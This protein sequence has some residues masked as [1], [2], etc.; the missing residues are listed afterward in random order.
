MKT[1][2]THAAIILA[3]VPFNPNSRH[4]HWGKHFYVVVAN[5][6]ACK[7]SPVVQAVPVSSKMKRNLPV[8]VE[9]FS[10]AFS[11]RSY[12]LADQLTLLPREILEDGKLSGILCA[13]EMR[14]IQSVIKKQLA[15]D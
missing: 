8:Q 1:T 13:E 10:E 11:K 7:F 4:T 12:A 15:L 5:P 9:I 2:I 6:A 3:D 14:K